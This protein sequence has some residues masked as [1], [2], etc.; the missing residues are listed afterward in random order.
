[1]TIRSYGP[2]YVT[3]PAGWTSVPVYIRIFDDSR[4]EK[5]EIFHIYIYANSLP[6]NINSGVIDHATVTIMDDDC[7]WL[8]ICT[9][10][11]AFA[12][13]IMYRTVQL[14]LN[15]TRIWVTG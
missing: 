10:L 9:Q 8:T 11:N 7:E 4:R 2:Y 3:I 1:M 15:D 6:Y 13:L 5:N 14:Q 12:I